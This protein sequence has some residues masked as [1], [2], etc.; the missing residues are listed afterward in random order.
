MRLLG[1]E[2]GNFLGQLLDDVTGAGIGL[3]VVPGQFAGDLVAAMSRIAPCSAARQL[4]TRLSR[5]NGKG[6]KAADRLSAIQAP[7]NASEESTNVQ[8]PMPLRSR[9]AAR[10]PAVSSSPLRTPGCPVQ[11]WTLSRR[12]FRSSSEPVA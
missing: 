5:M 11:R 8:E 9:S 3:V 6:S 10:S 4:S 7:R 12:G 1:A 2:R